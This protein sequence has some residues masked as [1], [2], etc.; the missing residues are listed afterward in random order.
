ME[1]R[2]IAGMAVGCLGVGALVVGVIPFSAGG[3]DGGEEPEP[4]LQPL[5]AKGR[6]PQG[7]YA[8]G[9]V[10]VRFRSDAPASARTA[11]RQQADVD[12][13]R[14][15]ALPGTQLLEL[16]H[17]ASVPDAVASL[18]RQPG[19]R[20]AEPNFVFHVAQALLPND[21][22]FSA[23]W[24]FNNYGQAVD[25]TAGAPDADADIPET[26]SNPGA[27]AP[28]GSNSITVA[29]VDSGIAY[30]HPELSPNIWH[31]P[32]E[33]GSGRESNG[34]DDD[35][36]GKV[37]DW[38]GWNFVLDLENNFHQTN[39]PRDLNG[40]GTHV[41]GTIG[42][43]GNNGQGIAGVNW[44]VNLM[45]LRAMDA[46]GD[47]YVSDIVDAFAYAKQKGAKIVNASLS[48]N[49]YSSALADSIE[50][51]PGVLFVVAAGNDGEDL[52]V[53]GNGA[54]P[55]EY[56]MSNIICVGASTQSDQLADFSNYGPQVDLAAPGTSILSTRPSYADRLLSED[57]ETDISADW[58]IPFSSSWQ[59]TT[60][61]AKSGSYAL[62]DSPGGNY[63]N[64]AY[65]SA[66]TR[67]GLDLDEPG[68]LGCRVFYQLRLD[69]EAPFDGL[70][71]QADGPDWIADLYG[72]TG[73]TG[74]SFARDSRALSGSGSG[75]DENAV[76]VRFLFVSD[77][78]GTADGAYVDDVEVGCLSGSYTGNEFEF[79]QGTSQATPLVAGVAALTWAQQ[80][81]LSLANVK[82]AVLGNVDKVPALAGKT[83]TGG[84]LNA[85]MPWPPFLNS[86]S[87]PSGSDNNHPLIRGRAQGPGMV[88]LYTNSGCEG[89]PAA[90][91]ESSVFPSGISV[92]VGDNTTTT[93]WARSSD[94]AGTSA[95]SASSITYR[96][97]TPTPP[98]CGGSVV[99]IL[100]APDAD[101]IEVRGTP[102]PDVISSRGGR[103]LVRGRGGNDKICGG[104]G[105]DTLVGGKGNDRLYGGGG[106][107]LCVGGP[108]RD[109]GAGCERRRTIP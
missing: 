59:R 36:N 53:P 32:G 91:A 17:G 67:F 22:R 19:V 70:L 52:G 107:D 95:C 71:V 31:N 37:D 93:F 54:Y 100:G 81:S 69:A 103:D 33:S 68:R 29:V 3:D 105:P 109:R 51:A 78:S 94:P 60:E 15:L 11:A 6:E 42:A 83:L 77:G 65:E 108:G 34:V 1:R 49:S 102:G 89:A 4:S 21:P 9:E 43:R 13:K 72:Y 58:E 26:W 7:R 76:R 12:V 39:D 35:H 87:P 24:G 14:T 64:N 79:E 38:R 28:T 62:S 80:P 27:P 20:Y 47:G 73:S 96:E 48:G 88:R 55:C 56:D 41:A 25:G 30:D 23:L 74:G 92:S 75:N 99:T 8:P 82:A 50:A 45:A 2:R 40:H 86:V 57:F 61:H 66:E 84:R 90:T 101:G 18:E 97:K 106:R 63:A 85:D 16:Q 104:G 10:I 5:R 44:Q 98:H 46:N